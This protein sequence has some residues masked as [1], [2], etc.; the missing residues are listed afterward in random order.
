[1][2]CRL[3]LLWVPKE[4]PRMAVFWGFEIDYGLCFLFLQP[5]FGRGPLLITRFQPK[6]NTLDVFVSLGHFT[7]SMHDFH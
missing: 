3:A 2:P 1:M 4:N 7:Q 5:Y 6:A